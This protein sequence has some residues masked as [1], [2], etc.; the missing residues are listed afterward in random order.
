MESSET[1]G[2]LVHAPAPCGSEVGNSVAPDDDHP[3]VHTNVM[4]INLSPD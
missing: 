3:V 4:Q 1:S 2:T